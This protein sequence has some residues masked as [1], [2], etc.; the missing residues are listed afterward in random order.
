VEEGFS[1]E[2]NLP[3]VMGAYTASRNDAP[4]TRFQR[5]PQKS[6]EGRGEEGQVEVPGE[7]RPERGGGERGAEVE[8]RAEKRVER[9]GVGRVP[10]QGQRFRRRAVRVERGQH[11]AHAR[12]QT[13]E[14]A[15]ETDARVARGVRLGVSLFF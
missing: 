7:R 3:S 9:D 8:E 4:A 13:R 10:T 14:L 15:R 2:K 5:A 12:G 6:P 1:I 11:H